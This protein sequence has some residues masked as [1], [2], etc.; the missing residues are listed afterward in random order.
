MML[1]VPDVTSRGYSF[2]FVD[3]TA[4]GFTPHPHGP[5]PQ[6]V[7]SELVE[8]VDLY[9]TL[10]HL[11][12]LPA[13]TVCPHDAR[14]SALCVEGTSLVPLIQKVRS[15]MCVCRERERELV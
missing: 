7:T 15:A 13:P 8:A 4:P 5:G 14:N 10:V 2:D 3:A 9:P 1:Y 11:A 12:G 6:H